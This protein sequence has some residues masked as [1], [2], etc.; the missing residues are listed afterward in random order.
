MAPIKP[1][2]NSNKSMEIR[3]VAPK[4]I[5]KK[6]KG[7]KKMKP[8]YAG[9]SMSFS[10]VFGGSNWTHE[11]MAGWIELHGGECTPEVTEETTHLICTIED[12]KKQTPQGIS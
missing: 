1:N 10:G 2:K 12:Y 3:K 8:I 4:A 11:K 7:S 9:K 5:S 6:A